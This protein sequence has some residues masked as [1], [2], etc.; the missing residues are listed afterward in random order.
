M[1]QLKDELP[2]IIL[3]QTSTTLI[4]Q[5]Q[6]ETSMQT[7]NQ[8]DS[9]LQTSNFE[10]DTPNPYHNSS[11]NENM[12]SA[13]L[14]QKEDIKNNYRGQINGNKSNL[15]LRYQDH[16]SQN[17]GN[18]QNSSTFDLLKSRNNNSHNDKHQARHYQ[19]QQATQRNLYE[20]STSSLPY[21]R[22]QFKLEKKCNSSLKQFLQKEK[23][24]KS[25]NLKKIEDQVE[26][27]DV[28]SSIDMK[29]GVDQ[30][31]N[32]L[33]TKIYKSLF[34]TEKKLFQNSNQQNPYDL[35]NVQPI[36]QNHNKNMK[37][38]DKISRL[39]KAGGGGDPVLGGRTNSSVNR[40]S[41]S[42]MQFYQGQGNDDTNSTYSVLSKDSLKKIQVP[43][44]IRDSPTG[45]IKDSPKIQ[46]E[47]QQ[48]GQKRESFLKVDR[49][50][51]NIYNPRRKIQSFKSPF[52]RDSYLTFRKEML[53]SN[54]YQDGTNNNN[55]LDSIRKDSSSSNNNNTLPIGTNNRFE[56][57]PVQ[58]AQ[59]EEEDEIVASQELSSNP[60]S[61][62]GSPIRIQMKISDNSI[63][64]SPKTDKKSPPNL[65]KIE[66]GKNSA[67]QS[68]THQSTARQKLPS[69]KSIRKRQLQKLKT[70]ISITLNQDKDG[71]QV[72]DKISNFFQFNEI[73]Q[74]KSIL[75]EKF[76]LFQRKSTMFERKP[77]YQQKLMQEKIIEDLDSIFFNQQ[78]DRGSTI[79]SSRSNN[80]LNNIGT[81][82]S[83]PQNN[84]Q[85]E[86]TSTNT[87]IKINIKRASTFIQPISL[88][89]E[90]IPSYN[91]G[92]DKQHSKIKEEEEN[93]SKTN[94]VTEDQSSFREDQSIMK[95]MRPKIMQ[96]LMKNNNF[97][98]LI[99][100]QRE[101]ITDRFH[102]LD[103][104]FIDAYELNENLHNN[105]FLAFD[106]DQNKNKITDQL[107]MF[108]KEIPL[109][110]QNIQQLKVD[111]TGVSEMKSKL[112][113]ENSL[114]KS[115]STEEL[116]LVNK[117]EH[118][119]NEQS[120]ISNNQIYQQF[121]N[122]H[123][124]S[125][126]KRLDKIQV[127]SRM[128]T[129]KED[130]KKYMS[131]NSIQRQQAEKFLE[132]QQSFRD[133]ELLKIEKSHY[134]E[135]GPSVQF[136][137]KNLDQ[138]FKMIENS[139]QALNLNQKAINNLKKQRNYGKWYL[140]I[141]DF[142]KTVDESI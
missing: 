28:Y 139:K 44:I 18:P 116:N 13:Y 136:K 65:F 121:W 102:S 42:G 5:S 35:S 17:Q 72:T 111:L 14:S 48:P 38:I 141:D 122:N 127:D 126:S 62:Q 23:G 60:N 70:T 29:K 90:R 43:N 88:M 119:L 123:E 85:D 89:G 128:P 56:I 53:T 63:N 112:M 80:N 61:K 31:L 131:N 75:R 45:R 40:Q 26:K 11:L 39:A 95:R 83:N 46:H 82:A 133:K 104:D 106:T 6:R 7:R 57:K 93:T 74:I 109:D 79:K 8:F 98:K 27:M 36:N 132:S 9:L 113:R 97:K 15:I 16:Q 138:Y 117:L 94:T 87:N 49:E 78:R 68:P 10:I 1:K 99:T 140:K 86:I 59:P 101:K 92:F 129:L 41:E 33:Q 137:K 22:E 4:P 73:G 55:V 21:L 34:P 51:M 3:R 134:H 66:G 125:L 69:E 81:H 130:L 67:V 84:T 71:E 115:K 12:G 124:T 118:L 91:Q 50:Q 20:N 52:S 64:S 107:Q 32:G 114:R 47:I 58:A 37:S 54:N 108:C 105:E 24:S 30:Y 76:N 2:S 25:D 120:T 19:T 110:K 142:K 103:N 96:N 135:Q 100:Q 77:L